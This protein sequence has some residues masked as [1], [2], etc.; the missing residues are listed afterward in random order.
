M[1]KKKAEPEIR[2]CHCGVQFRAKPRHRRYCS[3]D[4]R[5]AAWNERNPRQYENP[6]KHRALTK[7]RQLGASRS[8]ESEGL[9]EGD[10]PD[11]ARSAG[12][13]ASGE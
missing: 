12:Q 7:F 10:Q 11:P 3:Q 6:A 8:E 4:C 13:K 1:P 5:V 9:G 2:T